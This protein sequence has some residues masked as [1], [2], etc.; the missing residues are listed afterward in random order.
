[1]SKQNK[2]E[3]V[4]GL[5]EV[6]DAA[7]TTAR[8]SIAEVEP[9]ITT[10][11]IET[12]SEPEDLEVK[13]LMPAQEEIQPKPEPIEQSEPIISQPQTLEEPTQAKKM[14][15][16]NGK[17][18]DNKNYRQVTA[19]IKIRTY[20]EVKKALIDEAEKALIDEREKQDFSELV[21]E[22]L[23]NWLQSRR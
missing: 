20:A 7:Q 8:D 3:K 19:Y 14:G 18:S 22:L 13:V 10:A 23:D 15:R 12:E 2:F 4:S 6:L 17:R 16:P 9:I 11:V 1:M 5:K 21:E